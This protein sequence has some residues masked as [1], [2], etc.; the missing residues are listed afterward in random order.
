MSGWNTT[1]N[2]GWQV[3]R[4]RAAGVPRT[5]AR[6]SA[7]DIGIMV[8]AFIIHW[9]LGLAFLALKL[10]HQ[11]S[12]YQGNVFAFAREKWDN[13]VEM[14][15]SVI[16]GTA[17]TQS[18]GFGTRS[19]GNHAFDTW[20]RTELDRI[21]AERAKLRAAEREFASYREELL[22]AKDSEDF[23]RFMRSRNGGNA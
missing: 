8:V 1:G 5:S 17:S 19:S 6:W 12:G 22:H 11:S 16:G 9:E 7:P 10:W 13:L 23:D 3:R 20:R 14:T 18:F 4:E 2:Y 21:E 15:R